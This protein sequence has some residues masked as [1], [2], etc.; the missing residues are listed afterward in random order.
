MQ[1]LEVSSKRKG[2]A[3][4]N[5]LGEYMEEGEDNNSHTGHGGECKNERE[6]RADSDWIRDKMYPA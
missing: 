4:D 3:G 5:F 2:T 1:D 6:T